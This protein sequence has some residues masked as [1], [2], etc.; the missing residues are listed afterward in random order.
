[1]DRSLHTA[2]VTLC[3]GCVES[4]CNMHEL[5]QLKMMHGAM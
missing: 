1:M 2:R 3:K 4:P 5:L